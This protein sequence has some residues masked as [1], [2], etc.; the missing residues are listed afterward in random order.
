MPVCHRARRARDW[1]V[2][3]VERRLGGD[4]W[5]FALERQV[6]IVD[7]DLEV[8][9]DVAAVEQGADEPSSTR[10]HGADATFAP[11]RM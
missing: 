7:G 6:M 1:C 8:L 5:L 4:L 3:A 10:D 9:A 2:G 11:D